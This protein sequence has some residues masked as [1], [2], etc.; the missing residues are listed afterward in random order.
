VRA[1]VS[2]VMADMRSEAIAI[3]CYTLD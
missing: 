3:Q 1:K 2:R